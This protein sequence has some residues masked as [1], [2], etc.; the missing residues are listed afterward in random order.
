M[1]LNDFSAKLDNFLS[2]LFTF[3][4]NNHKMAQFLLPELTPI[5]L[6]PLV[7]FICPFSIDRKLNF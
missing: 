6:I 5:H 1:L 2:I 7:S 3:E 4:R